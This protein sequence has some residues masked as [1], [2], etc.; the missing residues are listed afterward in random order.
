MIIDEEW[1]KSYIKKKGTKIVIPKEA[2]VIKK[3]AFLCALNSI[4]NNPYEEIAIEVE[5]E[6]N[7][8]LEE[9][10]DQAF[11]C[12]NI[13]NQVLIPKNVR[14]IGEYV[15]YGYPINVKVEENSE[16]EVCETDMC[17][18]QEE[19]IKVPKKLKKLHIPRYANTKKI[20][21][22]QKCVFEVIEINNK[23]VQKIVLPEEKIEFN[24]KEYIV[25]FR[26]KKDKYVLI[27]KDYQ[28]YKYR[29]LDKKTLELLKSGKICIGAFNPME[30]PIF[31]YENIFEINLDD[32]EDKDRICLKSDE[33][34]EDFWAKYGTEEGKIYKKSEIEQIREK[35]YKVVSKINV[36]PEGVKDREKI[37]YAQ[38]VQNLY[39]ELIYDIEGSDLITEYK[40][41]KIDLEDEESQKKVDSTQN[42][43]GLLEG[44]TVCRGFAV[45]IEA[46]AKYFSLN[47]KVIG[48]D[49]HA[50]NLIVLDEEKYEDDFTW[51]RD[52]LAT[53]NL[54]GINTFL[55]GIDIEGNRSF[56][57]LK[58]HKIGTAFE[59]CKDLS[60]AE[61]INLL[62]TDWRDI[63]DWRNIDIRKTNKID[64]IV[65]QFE[66]FAESKKTVCR[67]ALNRLKGRI[68]HSDKSFQ[69]TLHELFDK[70][71]GEQ[72]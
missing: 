4:K 48:N 6:E 17:F 18:Y 15:F 66:D 19:S 39:N 21:V 33:N 9:I 49:E 58:H 13:I 71:R 54:A 51:Y 12:C 56:D 35:L 11:N 43:R 20:V 42:L 67:I 57:G 2:K 29:F 16:L 69:A 7:S 37:I 32:L 72:K 25:E 3:G 59:L 1:V 10:E 5:F 24:N 41:G 70:F 47:C 50:W 40:K 65:N 68:I 52:K 22:P 14:K 53:S 63:E 64:S 46:L 27:T 8:N 60:R 28:N 61:R 45:T 38:I 36:P 44:K 23:K 26:Q 62:A 55:R 30:N 34:G 31:Q